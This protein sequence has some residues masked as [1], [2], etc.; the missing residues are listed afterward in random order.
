MFGYNIGLLMDIAQEE[1]KA[2]NQQQRLIH[3]GI[4]IGQL[5]TFFQNVIMHARHH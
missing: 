3:L 2:V 5:I 1:K 4:L